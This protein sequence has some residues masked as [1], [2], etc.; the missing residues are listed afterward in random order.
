MRIG[1]VSLLLSAIGGQL[2]GQ[3]QQVGFVLAAQGGWKWVSNKNPTV[4]E[5]DPVSAQA[6]A[7]ASEQKAH[8]TIGMLDGTVKSFDCPPL[9][10]CVAAI[11]TFRPPDAGLYARL[12]AVGKTFF[13]QRETMPVY[14]ISRGASM[15]Q[16]QHAV[17]V[18]TD[19][20]L[21]LAPAIVHLDPGAFAIRLR[22]LQKGMSYSGSFTWDPPGSVAASIPGVEPGVYELIVSSTE[23]MR[24]GST[25][26]IVSTPANA[27]AQQAALEEGRKITAAWPRD[28]DPAAIH[29]FLT[30]LLLDIAKQA[31]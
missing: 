17:L 9:N 16:L 3:G 15:A 5:G 6:T 25:P 30:A 20:Q 21:Q 26:V 8:L 24:L 13:S 28:T 10:P 27:A 23:G 2:W 29:N 7:R 14:A 18:L 22:S 11:G 31:Q 1:V 4:A 19:R 12:M